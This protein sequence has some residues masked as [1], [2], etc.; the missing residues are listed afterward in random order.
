MGA[1]SYG[2]QTEFE[3]V[4]LESL[5]VIAPMLERMSV[6]EIIDGHLPVDPQ[7][8][9]GIGPLLSLLVAARL[10]SPVALSNVAQWAADSGADSL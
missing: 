7:A 4:A 5:A 2:S 9:F 6:R 8:K 3:S 1:I 10:Y